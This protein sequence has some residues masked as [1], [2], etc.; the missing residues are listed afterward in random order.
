MGRVGRG[1]LL[2]PCAA[3]SLYAHVGTWGPRRGRAKALAGPAAAAPAFRR[4]VG[5]ILAPATLLTPVW[6]AP[7][8]MRARFPLPG[9]PPVPA[10]ASLGLVAA[11]GGGGRLSQRP[12]SLMPRTGAAA[13]SLAQVQAAAA[14][15]RAM[16]RTPGTHRPS[17]LALPPRAL[18]FYPSD[19][20]GHAL[21][22]AGD[23][24]GA[25]QALLLGGGGNKSRGSVLAPP[26]PGCKP[27]CA[28]G[29]ATFPANAG[30]SLA[31]AAPCLPLT[32]RTAAPVAPHTGGPRAERAPCTG[33]AQQPCGAATAAPPAAG[34]A[35]ARRAGGASPATDGG[36]T[37]AECLRAQGQLYPGDVPWAVVPSE[38]RCPAD[39]VSGER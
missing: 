13:A 27:A 35:R 20:P 12:V 6:P 17:A 31:A 11:G 3:V 18:L 32:R 33:C 24:R 5:P 36:G 7:I 30:P 4:A 28:S 37:P 38:G 19:P 14:R 2:P 21:P 8:M 15:G 39:H 29:A 25:R 16:L 26:P 23:C 1:F 10:P 34:L 9:G 22:A